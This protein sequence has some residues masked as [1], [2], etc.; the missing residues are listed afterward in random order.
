[1]LAELI[2]KCTAG[3]KIVDI[4][5]A[6]DDAIEKCGHQDL[7]KLLCCCIVQGSHTSTICFFPQFAEIADGKVW[8]RA[9]ANLRLVGL[10][11]L[12]GP[13]IAGS[14]ECRATQKVFKGKKDKD[15]EKGIAFPTCVSVNR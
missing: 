2:K 10:L 4:C 15:V 5:A 13:L 14:M 9:P 11:H 12:H 3:T 6:G 7:Q 8:Q 1:M